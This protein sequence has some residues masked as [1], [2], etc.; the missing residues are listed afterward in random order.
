MITSS[1]DNIIRAILLRK[2]YTIHWYLD[3]LLAA[4]DCLREITFDD[5]QIINTEL[6]PLNDAFAAQI[7][8][9]AADI[10]KVGVRVGQFV[11][12]LVRVN[13]INP[14]EFMEE[15]ISEPYSDLVAQ[16]SSSIFNSL[17]TGNF[18]RT[19]TWNQYGENV[20]RLFGYNGGYSDTYQ[21][22]PERNEIQCNES[23]GFDAIVVEYIGDG[24][25]I[26]A[27]THIDPYAIATIEAY[28]LWQFKEMN[29]S[30]N[31]GEKERARQLYLKE[32][33]IL[34]AR[35]VNWSIS[36]IKRARQRTSYAAPKGG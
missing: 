30:Y 23:I 35:K 33:G 16:N 32:R 14:M 2:S 29:R 21:V 17:S 8:N 6:V 11:R 1:I 24:M 7:P 13:N 19:I 20:G 5:L 4:R 36:A 15:G 31:E 10:V 9:G 25:N 34:R 26:D 22:F 18:W 27:A 28:I 12:P 3:A